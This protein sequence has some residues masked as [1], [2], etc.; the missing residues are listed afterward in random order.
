M[1]LHRLGVFLDEDTAVTSS[2]DRSPEPSFSPTDDFDEADVFDG[3]PLQALRIQLAQRINASAHPSQ[4]INQLAIVDRRCAQAARQ[5]SRLILKAPKVLRVIRS[6]LR[7]AFDLD[8]DSLL[9]TEPKPPAV[10]QRV[11]NL[12]DRALRLLVLPSVPINLNH[13]T[14][15]SLKHAPT[16][17]LPFTPLEALRRVIALNLFAPL[18]QARSEYWQA[19]S[20]GSWLT[21]QE[22]WVELYTQQFADQAFVARQLDELSSGGAAL[23]QALVDAPAAEA[24]QRAGEQWARIRVSQLMWPGA[25][26]RL[27]PIPGALHIYR[28]GEPAGTPHVMYLPG[29]TRNY[30]EYP[31]CY[32]LQCGLVELINGALF[33]ELWQCLPLRR[34]HEA[35]RPSGVEAAAPSPDVGRG[36]A[37]TGDALAFSALA[38][39]EG[40]WENELAC[41]V[42]I[43]HAQVFSGRRPTSA[44]HAERFLA[45]FERTRRRWVGEARLGTLRRE[46]LNWDEQRRRHEII[47][48]STATG[49][50]M[51]TALQQIKRFEKG[52]VTLLDPLDPNAE[53]PALHA[54]AALEDQRKVQAQTLST[55]LKDAQ[56]Q[57][58]DSAFWTA[59]PAGKHKR[60][61]LLIYAWSSLLRSEIELQY[62]LAR[63]RTP[64]RDLLLDVLDK[65]LASQRQGSDTCVLSV[66]VGS[67]PDVFQPLHSLFAVTRAAALDD[68]E[69]RVPVVLCAFGR[70]GG[71]ATFASLGALTRSI[72][73]SLDGRDASLLWHYVERQTRAAVRAQAANQTLAVRYEPIEG[74]PVLFAFNRLLKCYVTL[75]RGMDGSPQVFSETQDAQLGRQL[76]AVELEAHLNAPASDALMQAKA[77]FDL[78]RTAAGAQKKLPAWL[79][80]ATAASHKRFK[81]LLGCYLRD[82]FAYE[83]RLKLRLPDLYTFARGILIDRLRKD[84]L[85]PK[86]D[87]DTPFIEMPDHVD[88]RFCGWENICVVG[89]RNELLTPSS[90]RTRLSLLQLAL[91]NLDP[92]MMPTRWRFKYA[93]YLQ[94][95]WKPLLSTDY[96]IDMVS[97]LD[98]GGQ[99]DALINRVFYPRTVMQNRL[100]S[101]RVPE[102][103]VRLLSAGCELDLDSAVHQ[104]LSVNAQSAFTTAMAAR[105]AEGLNKN[106]HQLQFHVVHLVGHTL[107]HDRYIAGILVLHDRLS[108]CCVVYWPTAPDAA[109]ITEHASL[110]DAHAHLNRRGA[111]PDNVTALSR[112]VAPG[113]AFEAITHYPGKTRGGWAMLRSLYMPPGYALVRGVWRG[114][115]FVRSFNIKHLEPTPRV[116]EIETQ[117]LEQIASDSLNWLAL[118]PTAHCDA[119]QLLYQA[120][121]LA[122]LR[123]AQANSNSSKV[124]ATYREQR[125]KDERATRTRA[126]LSMF[127]PFFGLGNQVYELLLLSRRYHR[128]GDPRDAVDVGFAAAFLAIDLLL[129]F[130]PGPKLKAGALAR[131]RARPMGAGFSRLDRSPVSPASAS[132]P[133]NQLKPLERFRLAGKPEDAVALKGFGE[134]GIYVKGG[135]HFIVDE[136]HHYPIHRRD[137]EA[138]FRL[139]NKDAPGTNELILTVKEPREWLLTADAPVA[140]PSS[141][142]LRP[143][144][145]PAEPV[146][147]QPPSVR[148]ATEARILQ[149]S[150]PG[151]DWFSWRARVPGAQSLSD[152]GGG[153]FHVHLEPPGFPYNAIYV[154]GRYDTAT[155][156]GIGYYRVLHPGNHAPLNRIAFIGRDELLV[157]PARVDIE[158]W[159]TTGL[160]EQPV[161]VSRTATGEWQLHAPLFSG[162]LEPE[163][164]R[165]FPSMMLKTREFTAARLIELAD[166]SRPATASHLL[167]VRATLDSWLTP[168][169]V[170]LGQT[171]D[172]LMMLRPFE[173]K[174]NTLLIG[175]E[176]KAPGFTRVDFS[177][178]EVLDPRLRTGGAQVTAQRQTVQRA[179]VRNVLEQQGFSVQEWQVRRSNIISHEAVVTHPGSTQLYYLCYHWVERANIL[180]QARLTDHWI[181]VAIKSQG[182]SALAVMVRDAMAEQ[183]LV[184]LVSGVQWARW[185][186]NLPPTV[187]IV[188]VNPL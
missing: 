58:F 30:Y 24:R 90:K 174:G 136:A 156:S 86:L 179:T 46:L 66:S 159:T 137:G 37:L 113:W 126:V 14:A 34:R 7:K 89:D 97:S 165:A 176:G 184:R 16:R 19:L 69:Q 96:L 118:V 25:G 140:G 161:P 138:F 151:N 82:A 110:Q 169:P 72:K 3:D 2:T 21:R 36:S 5:L 8:P 95:A 143:W 101:E 75:Q 57:L 129:T 71:V 64:H 117:V 162:P 20:P 180:L 74:N 125:V 105:T 63:V 111:L 77:H 132:L 144:P 13:F 1:A 145:A 134:R 39:L 55:L 153:V 142:A 54:F 9:F 150:V 44:I 61:D 119:E 155:Q 163:I 116:E 47:F 4:L 62:Q 94:P 175:Y 73:A 98:I 106:G 166:T 99:Y 127:V 65:P 102:L 115:D 48:A 6:E 12:T 114:I 51:N 128:S 59:R 81:Y 147:W 141:R 112:H 18:A 43:N 170:K 182:K 83:D 171:D 35:C 131:P 130:V 183:R 172:L 56:L 80:E 45:Y 122:L 186:G 38:V 188:R 50:A 11:D 28:E 53:T 93:Q 104:G 178:F 164:G 173:R 29:V 67:G 139:K 70:E 109:T 79:V 177:P 107:Q 157:S 31:S 33:D 17:R 52:L 148:T 32:Q 152:A 10:A 154:G 88:G 167:N 181:N 123:D 41:A 146:V 185:G 108:P 76:L 23:V 40:Q 100:S 133:V 187:Y 121:V 87:V 120:R 124:L 158:R 27:L 135:E 85:Y 49:L 42:S 91:H 103:L 78:V 60:V 92:Q 68:P 149:S 84:G 22:R 15:V 26:P 168:S 160:G